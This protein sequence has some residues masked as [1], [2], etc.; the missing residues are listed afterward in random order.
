MEAI[1][2][3]LNTGPW[4][5][6][7]FRMEMDDNG[8]CVSGSQAWA[9][10]THQHLRKS[11]WDIYTDGTVESLNA[12]IES[13]E[14]LGVKFNSL[15]V[16]FEERIES[17]YGVLNMGMNE[18]AM[19]HRHW[20]KVGNLHR[21]DHSRVN[22]LF[23]TLPDE[24]LRP[25]SDPINSSRRTHRI[26]F[27]KAESLLL[28]IHGRKGY[29]DKTTD[30]KH[31]S[32]AYKGLGLTVVEGKAKQDILVQV[33]AKPDQPVESVIAE[34]HSSAVQCVITG[35]WAGHFYGE[36]TAQMM[37]YF[38]YENSQSPKKARGAKAKYEE[39][40]V[41]YIKS[42]LSTLTGCG[43][44]H[45]GFTDNHAT[46]IPA[47]PDPSESSVPPLDLEWTEHAGRTR[48]TNPR[49]LELSPT[50]PKEHFWLYVNSL[51][52][53]HRISTSS[54]QS[55]SSDIS[56]MSVT[57]MLRQLDALKVQLAHAPQQ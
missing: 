9:F 14:R 45:A 7:E 17:S 19:L 2:D 35:R 27:S 12:T 13:L 34:F 20:G 30:R 46:C 49:M 23:E 40:G 31:G 51:P 52:Y 5:G 6:K 48:L 50:E 18:L 43:E 55:A 56:T 37:S 15:L 1:E 26:V 22:V 21:N 25:S 47:K 42:P 4:D 36:L 53:T 39:R 32:K 3:F 29:Q 10:F 16:N 8:F 33:I 38:W 44:G 57:S 11:D 24:Y 28:T 41:I 54:I